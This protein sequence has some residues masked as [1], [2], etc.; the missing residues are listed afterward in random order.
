MLL[1]PFHLNEILAALNLIR[2]HLFV[3]R[4][5]TDNSCSKEFDP[6]GLYVKDLATHS[7]IARYNSPDPLYTIPLHASATSAL[8]TQ[9]YALAATA[10]PTWHRRL[11]HLSS[12][13]LSKLFH[14]SFITCPRDFDHSLC[15]TCQL[16]RH[17]RL[18]FPSSASK[19]VRPFDLIHCY[20]WTSPIMGIFG[21][22]Y[23]LVILDNCSHYS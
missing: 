4:F 14:T 9:S 3:R 16:G 6:F 12:D 7:V 22:K 2:N 5:T 20:L 19:D 11:G 21:Y 13:V 17:I 15:H 18:P 10:S 8:A 1:E 23:Y